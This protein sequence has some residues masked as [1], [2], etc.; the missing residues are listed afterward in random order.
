MSFVLI[1]LGPSS[2]PQ[3][4]P[5]SQPPLSFP[6]TKPESQPPLSTSVYPTIK[7]G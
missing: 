3:T 7:I 5:E 6:Q 2:F 4:K 1:V